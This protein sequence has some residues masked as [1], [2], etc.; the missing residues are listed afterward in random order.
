M[1]DR[2]G[3]VNINIIRVTAKINRVRFE[4]L[5][6]E[7]FHLGRHKTSVWKVSYKRIDERNSIPRHIKLTV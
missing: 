6:V 2:R 5:I 3:D 4:N 7:N 1:G